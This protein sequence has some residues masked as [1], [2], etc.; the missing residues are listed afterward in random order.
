M[1]LK[2]FL[3]Q[4]G[5]QTGSAR[6]QDQFETV[7]DGF[8]TVS[9]RVQDVRIEKTEKIAILAGDIAAARGPSPLPPRPPAVMAPARIVKFK[10]LE[11]KIGK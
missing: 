3:R 11:T 8:E 1:V 6:L 4:N 10:K 7:S 5:L 2:T 9:R